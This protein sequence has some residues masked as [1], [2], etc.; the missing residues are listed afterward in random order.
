MGSLLCAALLLSP[1]ILNCA[2]SGAERLLGQ[3]YWGGFGAAMTVVEN[4]AVIEFDCAMGYV[5]NPVYIQHDGHFSVPGEFVP[6]TGGPARLSDP[7]TQGTPAV[8]SG[9]VSDSRLLL[10]VYMPG[11][12]RTIGPFTLIESQLATLEKCL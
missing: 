6:D 2:N 12:G 8:F 1:G 4:G 10:H 11:E 5:R 9:E 3:G 7:E